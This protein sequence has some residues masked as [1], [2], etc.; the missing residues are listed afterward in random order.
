MATVKLRFDL[1]TYGFFLLAFDK[2]YDLILGKSPTWF[3]VW[4]C[5]GLGALSAIL[6]LIFPAK[7]DG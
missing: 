6:Y 2:A 1:Y 5:A 7:K 3:S 4:V